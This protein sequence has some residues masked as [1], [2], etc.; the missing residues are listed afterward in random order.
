MGANC[1]KHTLDERKLECSMCLLEEVKSQRTI[2]D[3]LPKLA[4]GRT[5]LWG[6]VV[7]SLGLRVYTVVD[8]AKHG[9]VHLGNGRGS[10][11]W[12]RAVDHYSTKAEAEAAAEAAR[13][14]AIQGG[15]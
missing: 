4:S 7:W 5:C 3:K 10:C 8:I 15:E 6:D 1:H 9:L 11:F 2:V 13:A 14:A 12:R